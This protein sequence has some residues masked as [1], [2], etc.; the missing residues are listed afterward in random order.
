MGDISAVTAVVLDSGSTAQILLAG[1]LDLTTAAV[2]GPAV[3]SLLL[4]PAT[5]CIEI[6][7]AL[8][9]FC[10]SS[11]LSALLSA[12]KLAATRDVRLYLIQIGPRLELLL[13]VTG[14]GP[15]LGTPS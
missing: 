1:D 5:R 7:V 3:R 9:S 13:D 11:G 12:Q 2:L 15:M 8:V 10:D 6:D 14:L 4:D